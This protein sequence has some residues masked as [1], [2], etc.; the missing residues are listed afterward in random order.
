MQKCPFSLR[1]LRKNMSKTLFA[2][3]S[4]SAWQI[5]PNFCVQKI[6]ETSTP[7]SGQHPCKSILFKLWPLLGW[8]TQVWCAKFWKPTKHAKKKNLTPLWSQNKVCDMCFWVQNGNQIAQ[9]VLEKMPLLVFLQSLRGF[10]AFFFN[11]LFGGQFSPRNTH[12]MQ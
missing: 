8:R 7:M 11:Y 9:I 5:W 2:L 10:F 3:F 12:T 4:K 6:C 1:F